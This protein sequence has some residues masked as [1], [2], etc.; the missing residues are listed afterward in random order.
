MESMVAGIRSWFAAALAQAP[1]S[2]LTVGVKLVKLA[3]LKITLPSRDGGGG[4]G[5]MVILKG[6]ID[7]GTWAISISAGPRGAGSSPGVAGFLAVLMAQQTRM[8]G[9]MKHCK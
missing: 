2:K 7:V 3:A 5:G 9:V 6:A 4:G 1:T 8:Y